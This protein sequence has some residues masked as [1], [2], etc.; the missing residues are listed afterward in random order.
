M[1]RG[2]VSGLGVINILGV[3]SE[4][5]CEDEA[6]IPAVVHVPSYLN[7]KWR[8]V[9]V[10]DY[11]PAFAAG[12]VSFLRSRHMNA[13]SKK[14]GIVYLGDL[15]QNVSEYQAAEDELRKA[16]MQLVH[17]EQVQTNQASFVSEMSRMRAA[18]AT[19]TAKPHSAPP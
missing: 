10:I 18:S 12:E 3:T 9:L 2:A 15:P 13:A 14:I 8:S 5:D 11:L 1:L 16:K 19:S 4:V 17:V 6:G 7:P